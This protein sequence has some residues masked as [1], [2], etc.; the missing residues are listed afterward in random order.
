MLEYAASLP[1][2]WIIPVFFVLGYTV[3]AVA[4]VHALLKARRP[5]SALGWAAAII[6]LPFAGSLAYFLFGISRVDSRAARLMGDRAARRLRFL[7]E[8]ADLWKNEVFQA[9]S[10]EL[11][12]DAL[13]RVGEGKRSSLPLL[14]GNDVR[15]LFNGD[16]AYPAML[17]AIRRAKREVFLCTY[18]F[19]GRLAGEVF[20]EALTSAVGR[21]V[22]VRVLLDV[23]R[24]SKN[25]CPRV[26]NTSVTTYCWTIKNNRLSS[27]PARIWPVNR[28]SSGKL[29]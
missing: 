23:T 13:A 12:R 19:E 26:R 3:A 28:L 18:I 20:A 1:W 9:P 11:A 25:N 21:G 29:P 6:S 17:E 8:N 4:L 22:D 5:Q 2:G 10:V 7:S 16:E 24:L 15:P 27:L 14:G